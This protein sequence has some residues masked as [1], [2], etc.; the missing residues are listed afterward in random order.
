MIERIRG[1]LLSVDDDGL[2][3]ETGGFAFR[4]QVPLPAARDL[5]PLLVS[6]G[7][8]DVVLYTHLLIRPESWQL[9]GF[10]TE[11][12]RRLFRLLL[13]IPGVGPRTALA[14]L[15][16]M[17]GAALQEAV[18]LGDSKR[19]ESV[20]GIGKRMAAR[21]VT[22]L[23]GKVAFACEAGGAPIPGGAPADAVQALLALGVPQPQ[24]GE[25]VR[26]AIRA[27]TPADDAATLVA[28][29]LRMM[30]RAERPA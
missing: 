26:A 16:H 19:L 7:E 30:N 4:L 22:E 18:A 1:R 15:S 29:A 5:L 28:S 24:A 17:P 3:I 23:A 8:R 21:I 25:L 14:A 11:E 13:D 12:S 10:V 6:E 2:V 9:F 27:S 20:P